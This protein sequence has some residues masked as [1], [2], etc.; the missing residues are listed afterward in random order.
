MWRGTNALGQHGPSNIIDPYQKEYREVS[1]RAVIE[2]QLL[3]LNLDLLFL[4]GARKRSKRASE[5]LKGQVRTETSQ[6]GAETCALPCHVM[7]I[8]SL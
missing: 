7:P 3:S 6:R 2:A 1:K 5:H 8:S 4:C